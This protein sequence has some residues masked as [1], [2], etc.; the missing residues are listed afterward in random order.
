MNY[1]SDVIHP[2]YMYNL[3]RPA[4]EWTWDAVNEKVFAEMKRLLTQAPVLAYFDPCK[5]LSC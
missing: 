1:L 2:I 3:A 5:G 4:S